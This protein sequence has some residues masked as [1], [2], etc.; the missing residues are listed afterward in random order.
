VTKTLAELGADVKAGRPENNVSRS[1]QFD[2]PRERKTHYRKL[3]R[4]VF[5]TITMG[6][7]NCISL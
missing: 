1:E 7:R 4:F 2:L 3:V 5:W 6:A